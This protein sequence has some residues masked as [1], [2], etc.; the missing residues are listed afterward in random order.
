MFKSFLVGLVLLAVGL[1]T[2]IFTNLNT[3]LQI[4]A[5]I[6]L[7]LILLAAVFSGALVSGD[8]IRAN[9]DDET[10]EDTKRRRVWS[11]NLFLAG[12]PGIL[13]YIFYYIIRR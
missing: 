4:S 7:V 1:I 10:A 12:L 2:A 9:Y 6:G 3:G 13:A 8:R 5:G 11:T